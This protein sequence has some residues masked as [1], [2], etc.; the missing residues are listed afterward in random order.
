MSLYAK[1]AKVEE[2]V[3]FIEGNL[4]LPQ[5]RNLLVRHQVL[6]TNTRQV[7]ITDTLLSPKPYIATIPPRF[8][9]LPV[10]IEGADSIYLSVNDLLVELPRT[11]PKSLFTPGGNTTVRFVLEPP[12]SN[13]LVV[14]TNPTTKTIEGAVY[15][16]LAVLLDDDPTLWK[17][18]LRKNKDDKKAI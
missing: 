11:F 15:Y 4:G 18:I 12:I 3:A 10:A 2:K 17:L 5:R 6:N 16:V 1:L 9:N 14:Y 8:V 13:N 7:V